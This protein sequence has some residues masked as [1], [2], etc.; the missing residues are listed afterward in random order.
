MSIK[1]CTCGSVLR[2]IITESNLSYRCGSC[3]KQYAHEP[4][5]TL[6]Y[7]DKKLTNIDNIGNIIE[8]APYDRTNFREMGTCK[9]CKK[10]APIVCI[11]PGDE[12]TVVYTCELCKKSWTA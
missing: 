10:H 1:L 8:S 6:F 4:A 2:R 12:M 5:D 3:G 9:F 7:E 11:T